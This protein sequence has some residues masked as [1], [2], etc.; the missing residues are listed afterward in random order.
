MFISLHR[1]S[2]KTEVVVNL[3]NVALFATAEEDGDPH[4]C[5]WFA[6]RDDDS[7]DLVETVP[8]IVVML[9]ELPKKW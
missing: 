4:A 5:I 7:L 2:D 6:G 9:K 3:D 1:M 8:E